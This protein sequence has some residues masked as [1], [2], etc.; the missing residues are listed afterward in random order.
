MNEIIQNIMDTVNKKG[1]QS[2]C[3]KILKKCSMK[4]AIDT[5]LITELAIW[6]YVYDYKSEAVS[7][8]DLFK[9]EVLMG[10]IHYGTISTMPGV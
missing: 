5:G 2:N 3:R 4:S 9:N 1:I 7:V 8:C 10:I 6:L